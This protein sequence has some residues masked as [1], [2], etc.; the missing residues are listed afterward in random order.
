MNEQYCSFLR[1]LMELNKDL[2][3]LIERAWAING[4]LDCEIEQSIKL[5][6]FCSKHGRLCNVADQI[7][8]EERQSLIAIR[9][10]L[11]QVEN[12]LLF[13]QKLL[14]WQEREKNEAVIRLKESRT[15]LMELVRSYEGKAPDVL[16]E[17]NVCFGDNDD[18]VV[19]HNFKDGDPNNK[20]WKHYW[21]KPFGFAMKC[22][23]FSAT[24]SY[25][26]HFSHNSSSRSNKFF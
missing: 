10:S 24:I 5:C 3:C 25:M 22:L 2:K 17:L 14:C 13:Q 26:I 9:D 7:P 11:K 21:P 6:K 4:K 8:V 16:R 12:T 23:M 19:L 18:V 15:T 1:P 20:W